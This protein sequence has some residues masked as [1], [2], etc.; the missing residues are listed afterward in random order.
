MPAG[1]PPAINAGSVE[2]GRTFLVD[3]DEIIVD[4]GFNGRSYA[5]DPAFINWLAADFHE[6]GQ[7]QAVGVRRDSDHCLHLTYGHSRLIAAQQLVELQQGD[8]EHG[9]SP[10]FK[11]RC[12]LEDQEPRDAFLANL[13]ENLGRNNLSPVDIGHNVRR[14]QDEY[15]LSL[16]EIEG[17]I[18]G[19]KKSRLAQ[20]AKL[21]LLSP[22]LQRRV[23]NGELAVDAAVALIPANGSGLTDTAHMEQV[24]Q[25]ADK[26]YHEAKS[27]AG[28]GKV[29]VDVVRETQ[30]AAEAATGDGTPARRT[31]AP[32]R[33]TYRTSKEL[34]ATLETYELDENSPSSVLAS[35]IIKWVRNEWGDRK[36][37]ATFVA[38]G[39]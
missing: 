5:P 11:I 18:P 36:L 22:D 34:A 26:A 39:K 14:L 8:P 23:H 35:A 2:T 12:E 21:P 4:P 20:L 24:A 9:D 6:N 15:G 27:A 13:R 37:K 29:T 33:V 16:R 3:P 38:L 25:A 7:I 30:A 17:K 10:T 31:R 19:L 1:R 28:E 32:A